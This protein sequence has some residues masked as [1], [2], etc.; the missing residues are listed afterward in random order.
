MR[1]RAL[2]AGKLPASLLGTMLRRYAV[3]KDPRVVVGPS[4]GE[5][6]TAIEMTGGTLLAKTDPITFVTDEIG[7]YAIHVNANDIATMGGEPRWFLATVLLPEADTGEG[8][9]EEIFSELHAACAELGVALCGGHTEITAGVDRP[10]VVGCMLGEVEKGRL[11]RTADARP[12]D[13]VL[14][15]KAAA[16]EATSILARE[17]ASE[18]TGKCSEDLL[19]RCRDFIHDP[20]IS[21]LDEA[22]IASDFKGVHAMHDP[23][24]GGVTTGLWEIAEAAGVGLIVD[25]AAIPVREET[26]TLCRICGIDPLGAIAS[27]ALLIAVDPEATDALVARMRGAGIPCVRVGW[28]VEKSRGVKMHSP[29]GFQDL[30]VFARDEIARLFEGPM[31]EEEISEKLDRLRASETERDCASCAEQDSEDRG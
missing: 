15:T 6:A 30:T 28:V 23:T 22:R 29:S 18:L 13:D 27:G 24:E 20:G 2:R 5:D 16:I 21:V 17:K 10:I 26:A 11:L 25:P 12:G 19:A 8:D 4:V 31:T 1:G 7:I 3:C 14:I 9:V